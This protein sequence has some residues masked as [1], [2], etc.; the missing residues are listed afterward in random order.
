MQGIS[1]TEHRILLASFRKFEHM[2]KIVGDR[3]ET[4]DDANMRKNMEELDALYDKFQILFAQLERCT[5]DY[6]L[7]KKSTRSMI[8]RSIRKLM[9]I[10]QTENDS[11]VNKKTA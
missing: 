3:I 8:N 5:K 11:I 10:F 9:P 4:A 1:S 7:K 6:E 2:S